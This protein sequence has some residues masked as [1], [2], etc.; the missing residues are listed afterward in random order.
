MLLLSFSHSVLSLC[1]P[2]ACSLPGFPVLCHLLELAQTLVHWVS[3]AIQPSHPT[4][5]PFPPAFNLSRH[6]GLQLAEVRRH[7][8]CSVASVVSVEGVCNSLGSV[9]PPQQKFEVMDGSVFQL[10]VTAQ[11]YLASKRKYILES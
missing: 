6:Q 3:D 2:V 8:V 5:S 4:P 9:S 11:F 7:S 10:R 1:D